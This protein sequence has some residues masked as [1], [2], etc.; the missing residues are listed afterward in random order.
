MIQL[1]E[2]NLKELE[3]FLLEIPAKF[4]NPILQYLSKIAQEQ[5]PPVEEAKQD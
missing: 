3:A 5:N 4:A 2:S 1:S